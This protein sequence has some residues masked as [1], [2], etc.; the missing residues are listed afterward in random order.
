MHTRYIP[1]LLLKDGGLYKTR[2]FGKETYLGDP[3]N[4]IKIFN[5]KLVD[6]LVF[7][8]IAAARRKSEPNFEILKEI[9]GECFMPLTYGGGLVAIEQVREILAIGFEKVVV[10]SAAWTDP[11]LVSALARYFGSSTIVGS[12]DVKRDWMRRE[13]VFIHGGSEAISIDVVDWAQELEKRGIGEIMINSIDKD[14]EMTGY[15][16]DLIRRVSSAVSVPVIAAGGARNVNDLKSAI[17]DAGASASAA[18]SM[19]V[20]QGKHRAVL[21]SYPSTKER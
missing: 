1:V 15:D 13:K 7:L 20:F 21:I 14:G 17:S 2:K 12:I 16:L 3:I 4:T 18:G 9:A 8:D 5:D 6:E 19:F 11:T 10:N